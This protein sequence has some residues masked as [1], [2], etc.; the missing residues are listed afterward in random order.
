[1]KC[2]LWLSVYYGIDLSTEESVKT[3]LESWFQF[4]KEEF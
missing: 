1:M 4:L 3:S 2:M